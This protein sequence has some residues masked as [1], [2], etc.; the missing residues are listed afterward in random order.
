MDWSFL[1]IFKRADFNTFMFSLAV[2]GWIMIYYNPDMFYLKM[3]AILC[4]VYCVTRFAIYLFNR[5]QT[6]KINK[7]NARYEQEQKEK[8]ANER[9]IQAQYVYDRLS[10]KHKKIL[11]EVVSNSERCSYNDV[12][13]LR[14]KDS[15]FL[16]FTQIRSLLLSDNMIHSWVSIDESL[17]TFFIHIKAPLNLIIEN[18]SNK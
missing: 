17:D 13:I 14:D 5:Y 10:N 9:N 15:Y 11:F 7:A 3:I 6:N 2:T 16:L 18:Q 4:S 8:R 1:N 12:Y